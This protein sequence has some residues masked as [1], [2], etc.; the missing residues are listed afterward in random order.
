MS[1]AGKKSYM[2]Q[3]L[4]TVF[5]KNPNSMQQMTRGMPARK[6]STHSARRM[7]EIEAKLTKKCS[8]L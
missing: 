4:E 7:P 1:H 5:P 6:R 8:R 2:R 3:T